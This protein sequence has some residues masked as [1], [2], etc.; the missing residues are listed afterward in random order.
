MSD[1]PVWHHTYRSFGEAIGLNLRTIKTM[2]ANGE[3][4]VVRFGSGKKPIVR[5]EPPS[6][7]LAR[8]GRYSGSVEPAA[9]E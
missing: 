9:A 3:V 1:I 8:H 6:E 4:R 2:A 7:F 5:L